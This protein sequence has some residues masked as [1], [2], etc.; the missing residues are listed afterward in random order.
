M[1]PA[2][3][4]DQWF[5]KVR[6]LAFTYYLAGSLRAAAVQFTQNFVT[7]IPFLAREMKGKGWMGAE[8]Q[9]IKAMWDVSMGRLSEEERFMDHEM[10]ARGVANDQYI[11][12]ISDEIG[13]WKGEMWGKVSRIMAYPFSQ[14]EIFNRRAAAL[15]GFRS[16]RDQGMNYEEAVSKARDFIYDTHYLMTKA[17]LPHAARGGDIPAKSIGTA[18][19][20]RRFTHNYILSMI[21]SLRGP[22][23]KFHMQNIDVF[24]RSLA[25]LFV[26]AGL[27]GLPFLDDLLDEMERFFGRPYREDVRKWLG[28]VGGEP[29]E[30][31]AVAGLPAL[32]GQ[33]DGMVGVDLSG[34][35]RIG[36]PRLSEPTQGVSETVFGVWGGLGKKLSGAYEAAGRDDYLR[37][38]EFASPAFIENILKAIRMNTM[39]ATTPTGKVLYDAKGRPIK[40]TAGEAAAQVMGFRPERIASM[41]STHRGFV[42]VDSNFAQIRNDLYAR[43]RLAQT[44]AQRQEIIRDIQRYNL[45]AQKYRGAIPMINAVSLKK[46]AMSKP[47]KAYMIFGRA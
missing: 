14:M 42:N 34:S 35:L 1:A 39:G 15:A 4:G 41:S 6:S 45:D 28:Q 5:S 12:Q 2:C 32:L 46:S 13:G 37:A 18:Y 20:F 43:F 11:R 3:P 26:F 27:S 30:R 23:G 29:L 8:R 17:N 16:F 25:W 19:T 36:L 22:D 44:G 47:E 24:A 21:Y 38:V 10:I 9:Y 7:G 31:A 33:I 40:E